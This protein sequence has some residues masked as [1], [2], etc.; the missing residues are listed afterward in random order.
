MKTFNEKCYEIL[1]L[2][3]RGK[4]TT[5]GEIARKL[6]TRAYRAVGNAM[7][8]NPY[9]YF[10][11]SSEAI[12]NRRSALRGDSKRTSGL[13]LVPCHRVVGSDGKLVG[14]AHGLKKKSEMLKREGVEIKNGKIDLEKYGFK[15]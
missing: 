6:G 1:C 13:F 15:F 11:I 7:N 3:P 10:A 14:F 9:G 5:Y 8:K 2:V 12:G 4:V